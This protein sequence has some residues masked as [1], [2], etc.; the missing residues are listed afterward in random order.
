M[1]PWRWQFT[2]SIHVYFSVMYVY[3]CMCVCIHVGA[4]GAHGG[5]PKHATPSPPTPHPQE[6]SGPQITKNAIKLEQ[7][8]ITIW[9]LCTFIGTSGL[10]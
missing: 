9:D 10:F 4:C 3:V 8:K 1:P 6:L 7:I 5:T 2:I